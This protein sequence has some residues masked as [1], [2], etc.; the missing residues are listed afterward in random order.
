MQQLNTT[1]YGS[2]MERISNPHK[3]KKI[4]GNGTMDPTAPS[5]RVC[6]E[7]KGT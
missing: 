2:Q 6:P 1:D 7:I 3:K 4:V 5:R